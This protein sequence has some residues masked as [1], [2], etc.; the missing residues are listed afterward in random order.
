MYS[1]LV[2]WK[3][4]LFVWQIFS[5]RQY[6]HLALLHFSLSSHVLPRII[7]VFSST[8]NTCRRASLTEDHQPVMAPAAKT[9]DSL[10][11][12]DQAH[13]DV[14]PPTRP[15]AAQPGCGCWRL[16]EQVCLLFVGKY[17]YRWSSIMF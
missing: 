1:Q 14:L 12:E 11:R 6:T 13:T 9:F 10:W 2:T 7:E 8:P 15:A 3:P 16:A 17:I 5:H 4:L